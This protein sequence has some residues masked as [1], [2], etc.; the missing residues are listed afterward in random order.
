MQELFRHFITGR[1]LITFE[2]P[3]VISHMLFMTVAI[4]FL[5]L[6]AILVFTVGF[7][8]L[9]CMLDVYD[10]WVHTYALCVL[11]DSQWDLFCYYM[12]DVYIA[13]PSYLCL[14]CYGYRYGLF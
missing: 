5:F 4:S 8:C 3:Q 6:L 14:L 1:S 11:L 2:V 7:I 13:L 10:G 12:L 9:L